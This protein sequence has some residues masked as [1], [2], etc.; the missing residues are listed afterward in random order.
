M[1]VIVKAIK[2]AAR[3][4]RGNTAAAPTSTQPA[5]V[6]KNTAAQRAI[7]AITLSATRIKGQHKSPGL[8]ATNPL[9]SSSVRMDRASVQMATRAAH[10]LQT[11]GAAVPYQMQFAAAMANT[12]ARKATRATPVLGCARN[13]KTSP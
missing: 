3:T 5:A 1:E 12:A 11:N 6:M 2:L 7:L 8:C 9:R 13:N 4:A 10:K